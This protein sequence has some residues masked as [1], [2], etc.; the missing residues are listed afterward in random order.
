[1]LPAGGVFGGGECT[2]AG[3]VRQLVSTLA[4]CSRNTEVSIEVSAEA[5]TADKFYEG[6]CLQQW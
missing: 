1:V 4:S 2:P 5:H 6:E 3:L